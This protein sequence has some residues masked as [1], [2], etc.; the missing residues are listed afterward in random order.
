MSFL[1]KRRFLRQAK[2]EAALAIQLKVPSTLLRAIAE[3]RLT[4][5]S[6]CSIISP[7]RQILMGKQPSLS[8]FCKYLAQSFCCNY[9]GCQQ[10]FEDQPQNLLCMLRG[11]LHRQ[12][13]ISQDGHLLVYH[14]SLFWLSEAPSPA[15]C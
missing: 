2:A 3:L 12:D 8:S 5:F 9:Q 10:I 14:Y 13:L 7:L 4:N 6:T 11:R 1:S 15:Q